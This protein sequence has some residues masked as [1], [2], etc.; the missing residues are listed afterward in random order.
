M[1]E[2]LGVTVALFNCHLNNA[3]E[4]AKVAFIKRFDEASWKKEIQPFIDKGLMSITE[5]P[6]GYARWFVEAVAI[7]VNEN[8]GE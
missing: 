5:N 1:N 4:R 3:Q 8:R 7:F 6:N 2:Y